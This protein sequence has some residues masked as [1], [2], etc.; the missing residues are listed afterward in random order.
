MYL[1]K[2]KLMKN[3]SFIVLFIIYVLNV[4][5]GVLVIWMINYLYNIKL[6]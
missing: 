1:N 6:I 4:H 5:I 2:K 3:T